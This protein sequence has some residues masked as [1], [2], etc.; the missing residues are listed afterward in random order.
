MKTADDRMKRLNEV[1]K[2]VVDT[3]ITSI[4]NSELKSC[5]PGVDSRFSNDIQNLLVRMLGTLQLGLEVNIITIELALTVR[6]NI[7]IFVIYF[8]EVFFR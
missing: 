6:T 3:S 1:F 7:F 2:K 8:Y 5:F 4:G